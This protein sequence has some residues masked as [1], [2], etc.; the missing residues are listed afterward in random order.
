MIKKD[1][2]AQEKSVDVKSPEEKLNIVVIQLE[3]DELQFFIR[4]WLHS[5]QI[6]NKERM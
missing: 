6:P 3:S 4:T 5:K 2:G 1:E